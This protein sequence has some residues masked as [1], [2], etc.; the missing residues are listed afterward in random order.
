LAGVMTKRVAGA[1]REQRE[2]GRA[3]SDVGL[4]RTNYD[5]ANLHMILNRSFELP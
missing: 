1:L 5:A 2:K 3:L 4:G